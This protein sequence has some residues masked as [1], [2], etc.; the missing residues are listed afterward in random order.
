MISSTA[1]TAF[2]ARFMQRCLVGAERIEL[3]Y[4]PSEDAGLPLTDT[5]I[6]F[7]AGIEPAFQE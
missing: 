4:A 1:I 2:T 7:P 6:V 3:P 5:P